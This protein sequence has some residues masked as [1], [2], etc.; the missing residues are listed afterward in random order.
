MNYKKLKRSAAALSLALA[1]LVG[2]TAAAAGA[3][4]GGAGPEPRRPAA[5]ERLK[6]DD[7]D[8][9]DDDWNWDWDWDD[10]KWAEQE[11]RLAEEY[12][13]HG[14]TMDGKKYYYRGELVNVFLDQRADESFY[15]LDRDPKGTVSIKIV[16][17]KTGEIAGVE[18]MTPAEAQ[19]LFSDE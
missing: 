14:V 8:W 18:K 4:T 11:K 2:L 17:D 6:D 9:D 10:E 3:Y 15:T 1:A 13:A 7:W 5:Q 16:R 19:A 12:A